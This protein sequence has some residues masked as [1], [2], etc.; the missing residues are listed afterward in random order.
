MVSLS[1]VAEWRSVKLR[2]ETYSRLADLKES[3]L[4]NGASSLPKELRPAD[5]SLGEVMDFA[6][7]AA[8]Q[9]LK[10]PPKGRNSSK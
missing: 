1:T 7:R 5:L 2:Q 3:L 4:E 10:K 6:T 9:L 8:E